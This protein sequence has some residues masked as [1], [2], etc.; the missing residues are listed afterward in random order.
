MHLPGIDILTEGSTFYDSTNGTHEK[1]EP[2][3]I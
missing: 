3:F 2:E 1:Q